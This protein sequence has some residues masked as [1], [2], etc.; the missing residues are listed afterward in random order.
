M[1]YKSCLGTEYEV[2]PYF[3][4]YISNDSIALVLVGEGEYEGQRIAT[5]TVNLDGTPP[6]GC[7]YLD[8]NNCEDAERFVIE[9]GLAEPMNIYKDQGIVSIL[10]IVSTPSWSKGLKTLISLLIALNFVFNVRAKA[11]QG[12]NLRA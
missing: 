9:N 1:I 2:R 8:T 7:A 4:K 11:P 12:W 3:S 6:K 5:L 10:Y